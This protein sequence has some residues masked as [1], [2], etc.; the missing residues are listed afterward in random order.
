MAGMDTRYFRRWPTPDRAAGPQPH[1]ESP[2]P[3]DAGACPTR[4]SSCPV[5]G[6]R[7]G[8]QARPPGPTSQSAPA[9]RHRPPH[10]ARHWRGSHAL[11]C[12]RSQLPRNESG[13]PVRPVGP[14]RAL[15]AARASVVGS[16]AL[17]QGGDQA[18]D[19]LGVDFLGKL[20]AVGLD[21]PDAQHVQVVDLPAGAIAG[22]FLEAV[23]ELDRIAAAADLGAHDD[24]V[25]FGLGAHRLELHGLV[26]DLLERAGIAAHEQRLELVLELLLL[27]G[28]GLAPMA[29]DGRRLALARGDAPALGRLL[30]NDLQLAATTSRPQLGRV[31]EQGID[32]GALGAIV[33]GSGPT[34]A[35]LVRD[36]SSAIDLVVALKAS[37]LVDDVLRT[38][39]PVHGAR[40]I[41]TSR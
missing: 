21:Q 18:V 6:L 24:F 29:T 12:G 13:H 22:S 4:Q 39:G 8:H 16:I 25:V 28:R 36:E 31:L 2:T 33:S 27:L 30:H 7:D 40:V 38:H 11:T 3:A 15:G 35:F 14:C 23:I 34:C 17:G 10:G 19:A 20:A 5:R 41:S 37:G 9:R 32:Y 1:R 26:L